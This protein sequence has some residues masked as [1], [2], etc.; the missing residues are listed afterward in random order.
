MRKILTGL[1]V[2]IIGQSFAQT[3]FPQ[4]TGLE[5]HRNT[6]FIKEKVSAT[7]TATIILPHNIDINRLN[8]SLQ[9]DTCN[10]LQ[11][12]QTKP[13]YPQEYK[14]LQN[15]IEQLNQKL[16]TID[17][18][19]R[20]LEKIQLDPKGLDENI[21]KIGNIYEEKIK[22]REKTKK[23]ISQL[24]KKLEK[25]RK[26]YQTAIKL[27]TDCQTPQLKLKI[28]EKI[29]G[30]QQYSIYASTFNKKIKILNHLSIKNQ[31]DFEFRNISVEYYPYMKTP[32]IQPPPFNRPVFRTPKLYMKQAEALPQTQIIETETKFFYTVKSVNI[33]AKSS[34]KVSV[35][36]KEYPAEFSIFIDGYATATPFLMAV[37][38]PDQNFPPSMASFYVDGVF[39]GK[40]RLKPLSEGE[41]NKLYLGEDVFVKVNKYLKENKI[42]KAFLGKI[43]T[44][45]IWHY[46]IKNKHKKAMKIVLVDRVPVQ[47]TEEEEIQPISSKKWKKIEANGKIIWE[48]TLQ[49]DSTLE[50]DFGYK[51]I[52][53][54]E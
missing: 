7:S 34:V 39:I 2:L 47:R 44:T 31:T 23:Q 17:S 28:P 22:E 49:P 19:L 8:I 43:V 10:I 32:A 30:Q 48:F 36:K 45:K 46:T 11:I 27:K 33:P 35:Q 24:Q 14:N 5:I 52:R 6:A 38:K 37:F 21:S 40:G 20:A 51:I 16:Q 13:E 50:L 4:I 15:Q 42:E 25:I 1:A 18:Q 54:K 12:T 41:K 9:P 53:T 26:K 3:I 29:T